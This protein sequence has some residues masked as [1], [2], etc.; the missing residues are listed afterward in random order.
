MVKRLFFVITVIALLGV[1]LASC[2]NTDNAFATDVLCEEND[3]LMEQLSVL[4]SELEAIRL[5]VDE[6]IHENEQLT[7]E[8][9][10]A[11]KNGVTANENSEY[12]YEVAEIVEPITIF[13]SPGHG[14]Q[15]ITP[16][17]GTGGLVYGASPGNA[18][19]TPNMLEVA[20]RLRDKL[21]NAGFNVVLAREDNNTNPPPGV[22]TQM[23]RDAG[24]SF[25]L[26]LH[27]DVHVNEDWYQEVGR[28]RTNQSN[29]ATMVFGGGH[30]GISPE[31]AEQTAALSYIY[32]HIISAERAAVENRHVGT[33]G[34][35]ASSFPPGRGLTTHGNTPLEL[36]F[37]E[38]IPW[39]FSEF[40]AG[41]ENNMTEAGIQLYVEGLYNGIM[42]LGLK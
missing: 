34:N 25:G 12:N 2:N 1:V 18:H 16:V 29:G 35:I 4:R 30:A 27:S 8:L 9:V 40:A 14:N 33:R 28:Y 11:S 21:E 7:Y 41:P 32:A 36:L 26:S 19:E 42:A 23:A 31:I 20:F 15:S 10:Q 5:S 39:V 24:A 6:L 22:R 3:L 37:S 13:L 17:E 38:D